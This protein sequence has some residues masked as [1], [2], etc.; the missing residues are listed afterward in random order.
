MKSKRTW[1]VEIWYYPS[2][3]AAERRENLCSYRR[4]YATRRAA[5]RM[6]EDGDKRMGKRFSYAVPGGR[7]CRTPG[8]VG[9]DRKRAL[10]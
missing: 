9:G 5:L 4:D 3:E 2:D 8:G 6:I 1:T 7:G 10:Q